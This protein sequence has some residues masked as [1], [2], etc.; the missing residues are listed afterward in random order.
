MRDDTT[1][2]TNLQ[3]FA[4]T[5]LLCAPSDLQDMWIKTGEPEECRQLLTDLGF[6]DVEA[7]L[8]IMSA[9]LS[10]SRQPVTAAD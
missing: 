4:V 5:F 6:T 8:S 7:A 9:V 1:T 10:G 3:L 2:G